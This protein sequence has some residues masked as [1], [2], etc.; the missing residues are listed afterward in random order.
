MKLSS[1]LM[2][3]KQ[4]TGFDRS[5]S[6]SR[7]TRMPSFC[8]V[9]VV[10]RS[11]ILFLWILAFQNL[12]LI[13][14]IR[15]H[16]LHPCQKQPSTNIATRLW[17][18]KKSGLPNTPLGFSFQPEI[19]ALTSKPRSFFSVLLLFR[20]RIALMILERAGETLLNFPLGRNILS[21]ASTASHSFV[22][23]R[24]NRGCKPKKLVLR[25]ILPNPLGQAF[26]REHKMPDGGRKGLDFAVDSLLQV[27]GLHS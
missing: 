14:G 24:G 27:C 6:H 5:C 10:T 2:R 22:V 7:T 25:K 9:W 21:F 16:F 23:K 26:A 4:A 12:A 1:V 8:N 20:P 13:L 19:A 15:P 11:L 3:S 18:K 17:E